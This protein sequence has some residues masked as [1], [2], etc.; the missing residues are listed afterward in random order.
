MQ[1]DSL[2]RHFFNKV[3]F[4]PAAFVAGEFLTLVTIQK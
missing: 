3:S 1:T 2:S 4:D